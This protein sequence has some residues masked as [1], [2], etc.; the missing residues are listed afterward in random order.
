MALK[1]K[2]G[3][4]ENW[5]KAYQDYKASGA[6]QSRYCE[7]AGLSLWGFK[8]GIKLAKRAG[9]ISLGKGQLTAPQPKAPAFLPLQ[10]QMGDDEPDRSDGIAPYC[11]VRFNG[12]LGIR[13]ESAEAMAEFSRLMRVLR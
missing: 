8:A 1:T 13:I 6:T 3:T 11:E 9:L 2:A 10:V 5:A 12:A 4:L 7:A